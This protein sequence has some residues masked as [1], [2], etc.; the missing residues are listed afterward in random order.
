MFYFL[1]MEV[2]ILITY[3]IA[4]SLELGTNVADPE[5]WAKYIA[6]LPSTTHLGTI[7]QL[8][9]MLG[10]SLFYAEISDHMGHRV[11]KN[12]FT[13]K[14]HTPR[15]EARIF[16]F[17]DM[18][19]STKIA[20]EI[21]HV[22]YYELLRAYY[23]DLSDGIV[24][25][26]GEVYQYV[27]DE[28]IVSWPVEV[29]LKNHHCIGSF[30]AMKADLEKKADWYQAQFGLVPEFKA[31]MHVGTVTTGE[32]G[33]LKKEIVFTGDVLNATA[34]I[35]GQCNTIGVDLLISENL[36]AL[37]GNMA[38]VDLRSVGECALRGKQRAIELFTL[39]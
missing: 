9:F 11:L 1:L 28:V 12:L 2:V 35:Q 14:Y 39:E 4:A 26:D 23:D 5:V 16:M 8:A 36:V 38:N 22:R 15:E 20:E 18:K 13:G 33:A 6:F 30:L 37:L 7:T 17:S 32:I 19:S 10:I 34:R 31:G 21:G 29:G 24:N 3:P 25:F 27:G